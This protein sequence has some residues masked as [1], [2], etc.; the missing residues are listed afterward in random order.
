L[1]KLKL[2]WREI[3]DLPEEPETEPLLATTNNSY[4]VDALRKS[5]RFEPCQHSDALWVMRVL[6]MSQPVG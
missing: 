4:D 3:A 5:A 1:P 2:A 6:D